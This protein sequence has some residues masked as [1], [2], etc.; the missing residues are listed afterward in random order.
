R[1]PS[2]SEGRARRPDDPAERTRGRSPRRD[3]AAAQEAAGYA[4]PAGLPRPPARSDRRHPRQLGRRR[5]SKFLPCAGEFEETTADAIMK[6]LSDSEFVDGL[7]GRL[8]GV[9]LDHSGTCATCRAELDRL[10]A[11]VALAEA[12]AAEE[13]SPLFWAH[14]GS[15][16]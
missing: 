14:F 7:E 5:Q 16:V 9:R 1:R 12:D 13:P 4:H 10:R 6:H 2:R 11:A 3:C 15:R 8:S